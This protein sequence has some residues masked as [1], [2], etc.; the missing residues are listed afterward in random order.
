MAIGLSKNKWTTTETTAKK[1][2]TKPKQNG[3]VR[4]FC[5]SRA[6]QNRTKDGDTDDVDVDDDLDD[7]DDDADDD[8]DDDDDDDGVGINGRSVADSKRPWWVFLR[9]T[10]YFLL[11]FVDFDFDFYYFMIFFLGVADFP[12]P[13]FDRAA[14]LETGHHL[15]PYRVDFFKKIDY[16]LLLIY[17]ELLLFIIPSS[18]QVFN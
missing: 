11:V 5:F 2:K 6:Q 16:L 13:K 8:D 18:G 3:G 14:P 10:K 7:D 17:Y 4:P 12:W 9:K 1:N 15:V